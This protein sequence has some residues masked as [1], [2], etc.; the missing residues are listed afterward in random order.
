MNMQSFYHFLLL[1]FLGCQDNKKPQQ[2]FIKEKNIERPYYID[3]ICFCSLLILSSCGGNTK[4]SQ[5]SFWDD[6]NVIA[7]RQVINGDTVIVCDP[8]LIKQKKN[9]PLDLLVDD[10]NVIKL[11]NS[12]EDAFIGKSFPKLHLSTNYIGVTCYS[13]F[14]MKLFRR[15]GTFIRHIGSIGQGP[16]EYAVIDDIN[17]DEKNDRI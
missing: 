6:C 9:I 10:F 4:Q 5:K 7:T 11:D 2:H 13:S 1:L 8:A 16:G 12:I 15:D 3:L 17:I 14:P